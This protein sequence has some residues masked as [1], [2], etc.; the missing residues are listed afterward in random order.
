VLTVINFTLLLLNM[1]QTRPTTAQTVAP[2]LH[3]NVLEVVD[4]RNVVHARLGVK[5]Q[6]GPIEAHLETW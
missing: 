5:G 2:I 3:T 6:N 4:E 1:T